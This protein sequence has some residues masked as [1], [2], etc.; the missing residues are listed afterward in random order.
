MADSLFDTIFSIIESRKFISSAP[1]FTLAI[2]IIK[3]LQHTYSYVNEATVILD[4]CEV[5]ISEPLQKPLLGS[6]I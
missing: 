4:M 2:Q 1:F 5:V 6:I 3:N